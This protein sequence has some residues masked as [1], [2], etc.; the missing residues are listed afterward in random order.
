[1]E[2][3]AQCGV[4]CRAS[5]SKIGARAKF[6]L[7]GMDFEDGFTPVDIRTIDNNLLVEPARAAGLDRALQGV[8]VAAMMMTPEDVSNAS[9]S[10]NN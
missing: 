4:V 3:P 10:A 7:A 6:D 9:I 8:F 5:A 2:I 1:M